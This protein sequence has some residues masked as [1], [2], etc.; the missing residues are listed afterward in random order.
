MGST[1][2]NWDMN[3][4]AARLS[5][6]RPPARPFMATKPTFA[7]RH[8]STS[9]LRGGR[10]VAQRELQ[11]FVQAAA[12]TVER[13]LQLV[14]CHAYVAHLALGLR[15]LH[16]LVHARSVTG[17]IRLVDAVELMDVDVVRAQLGQRLLKVGPERLGG[18]AMVLVA[19]NAPRARPP[20]PAPRDARCSNRRAPCR[21]SACPRKRP[22]RAPQPRPL[23]CA[24]KAARR[25][26]SAARRSPCFQGHIAHG[27]PLSFPPATPL[28]CPARQTRQGKT[29][30]R[31]LSQ[32][33]KRS[34]K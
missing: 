3:A 34:P 16:A 20:R 21:S 14:R 22:R 7:R 25:T 12:H 17:S 5:A 19:T 9:S 2:S 13:H 6:M 8:S 10:Q 26:R 29:P 31:L 23:R 15:L 28:R 32:T 18:A 27:D 24:A 1:L 33:A 4:M 11:H 30:K